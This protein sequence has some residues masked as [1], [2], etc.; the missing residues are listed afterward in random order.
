MPLEA[1]TDPNAVL[2]AIAEFDEIGRDQ[3]LD[4]YGFLPARDV[5]LLH[6]ERRYDSSR[7][8]RLRTDISIRIWVRFVQAS[9]A[10]GDPRS[11]SW[12]NSGSESRD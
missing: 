10:V 8:S 6:Q 12:N 9:S 4:R 3:F 11:R 1:L 7:L 2:A 5:V